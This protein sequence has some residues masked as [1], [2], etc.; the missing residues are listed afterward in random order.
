LINDPA[1]EQASHEIERRT[2]DAWSWIARARAA[3]AKSVQPKP[4]ATQGDSGRRE[5]PPEQDAS[6]D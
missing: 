3:A 6:V 4:P 2:L 5:P 1:D